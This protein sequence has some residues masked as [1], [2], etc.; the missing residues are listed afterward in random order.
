[1][2]RMH[3]RMTA[4]LATVA[5]IGLS[6]LPTRA[7]GDTSTARARLHARVHSHSVTAALSTRTSGSSDDGPGTDDSGSVTTRSSPMKPVGGVG[8]LLG[9]G[10]SVPTAPTSGSSHHH[11]RRPRTSG[12]GHH[13]DD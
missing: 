8:P 11:R 5:A 13:H 7:L 4:T 2:R 12:A 3:S 9:G 1:M 10:S 6:V